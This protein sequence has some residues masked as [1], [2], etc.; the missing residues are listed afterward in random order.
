MLCL[1]VV[2]TEDEMGRNVCKYQG[3]NICY[4]NGE[5]DTDNFIGDAVECEKY[6]CT[7]EEDCNDEFRQY[8]IYNGERTVIECGE[9]LLAAQYDIPLPQGAKDMNGIIIPKKMIQELRRVLD[10]ATGD[11]NIQLNENKIKY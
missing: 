6:C 11:I 4:S 5:P 1:L 8:W 7:E 3:M 2:R 10:D 9:A